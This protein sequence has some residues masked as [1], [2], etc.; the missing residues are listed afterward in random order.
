[1]EKSSTLTFQF[2]DS[3]IDKLK[4]FYKENIVDSNN[5]YVLFLAKLNG[6]SITAY[7]TN[8]VVFQGK[9]ASEES[10]I[11]QEE[12]VK[13]VNSNE[14]IGSDEVGTGDYFGPISVCAAY[15]SSTDIKM[16]DML[17]I[18]DSKKID[19]D[20]IMKIAPILLKKIT[21]S[22]ISVSPQKYNRLIAA[23]YNQA[24]IKVL[25]HNQVL[26]NLKKKIGKEKIFT[27][28]DQFLSGKKYFEYLGDSKDLVRDIHFETKAE[29]KFPSVA[30][31]SIIARYSFL[32][33][34]KALS[35]LV[36]KEIPK[37]AGRQVDTFAQ[38]VLDKFG[39]EK[40]EK[41]VKIHFSNTRKLKV[42][43]S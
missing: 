9:N 30:T 22:Q 40:L 2:E 14:Q 17:G 33:K 27:V 7:K 34:M 11:W 35:N 15:V 26:F 13:W 4:E 32:I 23:G 24:K 3:K 43:E 12:Q 37:G 29:D 1:M 42:K 28:V 39:M 41:M 31:A 25:L 36:G 5:Q 38:K 6:V 19:D 21:Y 8:K 16:L 10:L 18:G 20:K